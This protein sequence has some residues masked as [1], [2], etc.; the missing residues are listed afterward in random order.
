MK[1]SDK[2]VAGICSANIGCIYY[3]F[4]DLYSVYRN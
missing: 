4:R 3:R 2:M 1:I